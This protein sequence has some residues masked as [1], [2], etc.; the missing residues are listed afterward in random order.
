M[1]GVR[2]ATVHRPRSKGRRRA[3][4]RDAC[5]HDDEFKYAQTT[6][7]KGRNVNDMK[8]K[9]VAIA[10]LLALCGCESQSINARGVQCR[11]SGMAMKSY[12]STNGSECVAKAPKVDRQ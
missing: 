1:Q 3:P 5:A 4:L 8:L 12:S 9:T 10:I 2:V 6:G 7:Q 11:E